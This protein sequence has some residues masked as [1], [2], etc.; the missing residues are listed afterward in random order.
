[1]I[2]VHYRYLHPSK[3]DPQKWHELYEWCMAHYGKHCLH[4][5]PW[6]GVKC[7]RTWGDRVPWTLFGK[8]EINCA[9]IYAASKYPAKRWD[10]D[11]VYPECRYHNER[12]G[13]RTEVDVRPEHYDR[14]NELF[15]WY[16][17]LIPRILGWVI[18]KIFSY[19]PPRKKWHKPRRR[20]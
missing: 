9:H 19:R 7:N 10:R 12:N 2:F 17:L 15:K 1:M 5:D 14:V 16:V 4:R 20:W 6:T 3:E 18:V 11:N 13:T 8:T